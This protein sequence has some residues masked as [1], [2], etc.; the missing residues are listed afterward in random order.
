MENIK[1]EGRQ[2]KKKPEKSINEQNCT[3]KVKE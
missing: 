3:E 1:T 2:N